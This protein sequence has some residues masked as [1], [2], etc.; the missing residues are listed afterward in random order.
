M[1]K[2][3]LSQ[4]FYAIYSAENNVVTYSDGGTLGKAVECSIE[5]EEAS[6]NVFYANNGPAESAADFAGGTLTITI[7]RLSPAS[8]APL[9]GLTTSTVSTPSGTSLAFKAGAARPYVG[10]GT[11]FRSLVD[12]AVVWLAVILT[13]VQFAIPADSASTQGETIEFSGHEL[14]AA[15]LRDD[16]ADHT[17]KLWGQFSTEAD[18]VT[19]IKSVLSI[20]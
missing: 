7:D 2:T 6:D 19:W 8:L 10:Y 14:S 11:V 20:T 13:K 9:L 16:T 1:A 15:I 17:W 3:G 12:N 4:S 18:A 5:P